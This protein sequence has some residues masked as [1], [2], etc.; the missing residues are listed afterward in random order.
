MTLNFQ[1]G[2]Y[3]CF[4]LPL[5]ATTPRVAIVDEA[6][7]ITYRIPQNSL[8]EYSNIMQHHFLQLSAPK[9]N[10]GLIGTT[11]T[12]VIQHQIAKNH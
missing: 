10:T 7:R 6:W 3:L 11:F 1:K 5:L 2:N 8:V 4:Y 12:R 9:N